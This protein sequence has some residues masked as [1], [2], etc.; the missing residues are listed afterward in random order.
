[1][2][3]EQ[4]DLAPAHWRRWESNLGPEGLISYRY[5]GCSSAAVSPHQAVGRMRIRSDLR[6][7]GGLLLAPLGIAMLDTAGINVDAIAQVAPTRI[8]L[9]VFP[10]A[11]EAEE[12]VVHGVVVREGRTQMFTE[13][14]FEDAGRPGRV[15]ALGSTSWAVMAPVPDG[16][17]Y[18]DPGPGI[19]D[20]PGLPS[21]AAAFGAT[22]RPQGGFVLE[23]LSTRVGSTSLHQGPIQVLLEAAA[24]QAAAEA[25]GGGALRER[26][27]GISIVR[28]GRFGPFTT[29]AEIV[30]AEGDLIA[31]RAE[32][33]DEGADGKPVATATYI[34]ER[35]A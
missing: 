16:Y 9:T 8:D 32:L 4:Q 25:T 13:T 2:E 6:A 26:Q 12:V 14:R 21:L 1:M 17:R 5:L 34:L 20:T 27:C 7:G 3:A 24:V 28:P 23:G 10:G 18:V 35:A 30:V 29:T 15:V 22:E 31:C 19:P 33:R 11:G